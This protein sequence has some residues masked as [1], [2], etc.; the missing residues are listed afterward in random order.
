MANN[1]YTTKTASLKATKIDARV[2]NGKMIKV[3]GK[4]VVTGISIPETREII[5]ENDLW[6]SKVEVIDGEIV[7]NDSGLVNPNGLEPWKPSIKLVEGN[8]AYDNLGFY[9]NIETD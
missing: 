4:D 9:C 8:K 5:T 3:N 7:L 1:L 2:I 6:T